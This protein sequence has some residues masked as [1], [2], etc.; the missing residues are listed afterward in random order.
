M[1]KPCK[2][3]NEVQAFRLCVQCANHPASLCHGVISLP[4]ILWNLVKRQNGD[5]IEMKFEI[6]NKFDKSSRTITSCQYTGV[7]GSIPEIL[8]YVPYESCFSWV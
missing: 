2:Q 1:I 6:G 5:G 7:H 8:I 3:R 4:L